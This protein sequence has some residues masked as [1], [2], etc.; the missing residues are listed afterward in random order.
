M[1]EASVTLTFQVQVEKQ[2]RGEG[3]NFFKIKKECVLKEVC[4]AP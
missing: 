3:E 2:K 4:A 1:K